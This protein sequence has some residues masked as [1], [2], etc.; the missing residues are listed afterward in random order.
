MSE[1]GLGYNVE[2]G[3]EFLGSKA[4]YIL[5]LSLLLGLEPI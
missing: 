1:L 5:L 4:M 2:V 3:D